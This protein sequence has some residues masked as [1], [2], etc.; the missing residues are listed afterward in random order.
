MRHDA[1]TPRTMIA[2]SSGSY[3]HSR[4]RSRRH[5]SHNVSHAPKYRN[6]SH[7]PS[8]LFCTFDASYVL[9]C[10][11]DKIVATNVGPKC[12]KGKTCIWV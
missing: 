3:T 1:F 4:S 2:S 7:D 8:I 5:A 9:Y 6:S 10:K 11:N 12:K